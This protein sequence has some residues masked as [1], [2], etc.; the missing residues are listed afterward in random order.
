MKKIDKY[1]SIKFLSSFFVSIALIVVI[2]VVFDIS[3]KIGIFV[4]NQVPIKGI[5]RHY[6][7]NFIPFLV[8]MFSFLF[9]FISVIYFTSRMAQNTE[10][11]A[12][13]SSGIS[14]RR[15]LLPYIVCAFLIG[16]LNS[17]LAN[18]LIPHLTKDRVAFE[19][20]YMKKEY[21]N[22]DSDIHIKFNDSTYFYLESFHHSAQIGRRF[23]EENFSGM[24]MKRKFSASTI[25]YDKSTNSWVA[26]D[27]VERILKEDGEIV[28][29]GPSKQIELPIGSMD[30]SQD[31]VK[32]EEMNFRELNEY[33]A[34]EKTRGSS[35]VSFL[36]FERWQRFLHPLAA[37]VLTLI[38]VALSA[39]TY[40]RKGL[41]LNLAL[42]ITLAF[43]FIVFMQFSKVFATVGG[44]PM[45]L[46]AL[47]PILIF[48]A[49]AFL[50]L[51]KRI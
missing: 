50:L 36:E 15:F 25:R 1:I 40:T 4:E 48:S 28:Q 51:R 31:F 21:I 19:R 7:L 33:I 3:E 41:G 24:Q 45:W 14:Y 2:I 26:I 20:Q 37:I 46:A 47:L 34:Q 30:F 8:N 38:G 49:V 13:L 17:A 32:V 18:F 44:F 9:I 23:T 42:G 5:V 11:T 29:S 6:Y 10:I 16:C 43:V 22:S 35:R 12:I 27:Y 39:I